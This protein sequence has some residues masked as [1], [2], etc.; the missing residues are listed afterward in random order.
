M[1]DTKAYGVAKGS[2]GSSSSSSGGGSVTYNY[3]CDTATYA[4]TAG[5]AD[6]ATEAGSAETAETATAA[7]YATKAGS[8]ARAE[9]ASY[10][11]DCSDDSA[12]NEKFLRKDEKDTAAALITFAEGLLSQGDITGT[13]DVVSS[14]FN[15]DEQTGFGIANQGSAK[16]KLFI[17]GLEVWGKAVFHQL[18][19]RELSYVGGDYVFSP[20]GSTLMQVD[21][22]TDDSGVITGWKCWLLADDGTT[23]TMN[24]WAAYDLARC[25]SFNIEEGVYEDVASRYYWRMVTEVSSE[26]SVITDADGNELYGG[27]KLHYVVLS[28]A[29]GEYDSDSDAP[30]AGDKIACFGH[31]ADD[32]DYDGSRTGLIEITTSDTYPALK[33]YYGVCSFTLE[34]TL[35]AKAAPDEV[36]FNSNKF[37][38]FTTTEGDAQSLEDY[39]Y[40]GVDGADAVAVAASIGAFTH[41][42][43]DEET[44]AVTFSVYEGSTALG[45]SAALAESC[46]AVAETTYPDGVTPL[47]V[48]VAG[49]FTFTLAAATEISGDLS[50]TITVYRDG[51]A[52]ET[53]TIAIPITTVMD[54]E[55]A[56]KGADGAD[57]ISIICSPSTLTYE[58][59]A[60][61]ALQ[62]GQTG[63]SGRVC[64]ISLYNG[65]TL[66]AIRDFAVTAV[67]GCVAGYSIAGGIVSLWLESI[68]EQTYTNASSGTTLSVP[69]GGGTVSCTAIY[70]DDDNEEQEVSFVVSFVVSS[71]Y[72]AAYLITES[73][74]ISLGVEDIDDG[75]RN[76]GI[77][78]EAGTVTIF[79]DNFTVQDSDEE[80]RIKTTEDGELA[81]TSYDGSGNALQLLLGGG[82]LLLQHALGGSIQMGFGSDGAPFIVGYDASGDITF[83][84]PSAKSTAGISLLKSYSSVSC[85]ATE[86]VL[87][88][89]FTLNLHFMVTNNGD[90]DI[91]VTADD[92]Y[93]EVSQGISGYATLQPEASVTV[94]AGNSTDYALAG[95]SLAFAGDIRVAKSSYVVKNLL[96]TLTFTIYLGDDSVATSYWYFS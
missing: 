19:I 86:G 58:T 83:Q 44:L 11:D 71:T 15:E 4:K 36:L 80:E 82:K 26:T 60:S 67:E 35:V 27:Q 54:G 5:T 43:E 22:I 13:G 68:D 70:D 92:C 49:V 33:I 42:Y 10:A 61:G 50:F 16:Y 29:D 12:F 37:K 96:S 14:T 46:W 59:D 3:T 63:S 7:D 87:Y 9:Y 28:N 73:D 78:I 64:T 23:A 1:I 55:A 53:R 47:T 89:V 62:E 32:P 8:A 17:N 20:A 66:G 38:I 31:S 77:D 21:E 18:E 45:Y 79:A 74:R 6:Y 94:S 24:Y 88:Y 81:L 75:L 56:E 52:T 90:A 76:T 40:N 91:T 84:L 2:S 48:S 25:Q 51:G 34:G 57:G 39:I 72:T 65:A 69:V 93:L 41:K 30:A 95:E 85:V